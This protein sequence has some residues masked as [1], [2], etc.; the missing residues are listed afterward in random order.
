MHIELT[1]HL[2]CPEA[3]A[4]AFLVLVPELMEGR[5]VVAG[6]LGCPVCGWSTAWRESIPDFGGGTRAV[7]PAPCD[8]AAAIAMLGLSGPGGWLALAGSAGG[9]AP[10]LAALLPGVSIVA[11]NPPAGVASVDPVSMIVSGAWP[12]KAQSMRGLILGADVV[13]WR[14]AALASV[15]PGLRAVGA[16]AEPPPLPGVELLA[17]ADD[18]WVVRRR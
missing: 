6:H 14:D 17:S 9:I 12:L 8:A 18:V 16:G 2:R 10:A 4:E 15:L 5:R 3:H 7:G 1:D 11:I 13:P